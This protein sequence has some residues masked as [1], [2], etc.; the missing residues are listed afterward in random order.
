M[1]QRFIPKL[2][3]NEK[4]ILGLTAFV[5]LLVFVDRFFFGPALSH[6][7]SLREDI[8]DKENSLKRYVRFLSYEDQISKEW[9]ILKKYYTEKQLTPGEI[10][11]VFLNK[12]EMLARAA[13]ISF[14]R[15]TPTE[16]ENKKDYTEYFANL[17]CA[18]KLKDIL[19]FMHAIDT[20]DEL[21]KIGKFNMN[22]KKT[23][24]EEITVSMTVSKIIVELDL[25]EENEKP[26]ISPPDFSESEE[27]K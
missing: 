16:G 17:E 5:L 8:Q 23:G 10:K 21:M 7:K 25:T 15:V 22:A 11:E 20:S 1:I 27:E 19:T 14:I 12:I 13:N 6:L 3:A 26:V 4:K 18:G 2:S 24:S 9:D